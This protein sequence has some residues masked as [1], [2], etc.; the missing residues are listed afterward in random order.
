M[1]GSTLTELNRRCPCGRQLDIMSFDAG[2]VLSMLM[3]AD[4][5]FVSGTVFCYIAFDIIMKHGGIKDFRVVQRARDSMEI[6]LVKDATFRDEILEMFTARVR[7]KSGAAMR[8]EYRFVP[9]IPPEKSGKR[10]FVSSEI[11]ESR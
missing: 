10:L 7:E 9:E 4:G 1:C 5:H 8:I 2:R 11:P 6:S 3:A